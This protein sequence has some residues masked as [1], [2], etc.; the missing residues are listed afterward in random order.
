MVNNLFDV[1][2]YLVC[3]FFVEDFC[4]YVQQQH[5]R[6]VFFSRGVSVSFDVRVILVSSNEFVGIPSIFIFWRCLGITDIN[7]SFNNW[8]NSAVNS[9]LRLLLL[10]GGFRL[11][12]QSLFLSLVFSGYFFSLQSLY[13]VCFQEFISSRLSNFWQVI[14]HNISYDPFL[15]LRYPL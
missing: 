10:L 6:I 8:Q 2:L 5:W 3:E 15:F 14:V 1:L 13:V 11:P 4:I 9:D 12:L 7:S